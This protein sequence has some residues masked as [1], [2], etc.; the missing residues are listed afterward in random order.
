MSVISGL[1]G[2]CFVLF[3]G[4]V[5]KTVRLETLCVCVRVCVVLLYMYIFLF[6]YISL[7]EISHVCYFL[8]FV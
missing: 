2:S 8:S 3:E 5:V 6:I 1:F 7:S 4:L